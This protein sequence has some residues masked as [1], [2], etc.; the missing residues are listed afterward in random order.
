MNQEMDGRKLTFGE[1]ARLSGKE[2]LTDKAK[3]ILQKR[4]RTASPVL[5]DIVGGTPNLLGG[6]MGN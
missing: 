3:A 2:P 6:S 1:E 4:E 5:Q